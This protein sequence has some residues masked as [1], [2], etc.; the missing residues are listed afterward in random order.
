MWILYH[1]YVRIC[2]V[3]NRKLKIT[4]NGHII[5]L[6]VYLLSFLVHYL[7]FFYISCSHLSITKSHSKLDIN[8]H[9]IKKFKSL[10]RYHIYVVL[11]SLVIHTSLTIVSIRLICWFC[12]S[13]KDFPFWIFFDF[14]NFVIL[15]SV[16]FKSSTSQLE[17]II[18]RMLKFSNWTLTSY[19]NYS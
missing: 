8:I 3:T 13:L 6:C 1:S 9:T 4:V 18:N 17:F 2:N 10:K 16:L 14:G 11:F 7:V 12:Q 15:L 19:W 5:V